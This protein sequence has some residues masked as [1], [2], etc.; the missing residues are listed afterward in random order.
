MS[1]KIDKSCVLS[2]KLIIEGTVSTQVKII[3]K[4]EAIETFKFGFGKLKSQDIKQFLI[5]C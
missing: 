3:I 5:K 2:E 4:R 1:R